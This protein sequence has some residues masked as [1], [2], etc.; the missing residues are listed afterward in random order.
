MPLD[1]STADDGAVHHF[2]A[3]IALLRLRRDPPPPPFVFDLDDVANLIA[4][5]KA[6]DEGGEP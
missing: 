4:A 6:F 1:E 3:F 2:W 5:V